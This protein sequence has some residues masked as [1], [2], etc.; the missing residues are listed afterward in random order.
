[1][2]MTVITETITLAIINGYPISRLLQP[3]SGI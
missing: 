2:E 3:K 1:M